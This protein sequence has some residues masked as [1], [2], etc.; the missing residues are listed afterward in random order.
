MLVRSP[1]RSSV[2]ITAVFNATRYTVTHLA[3]LTRTT[4]ILLSLTRRRRHTHTTLNMHSICRFIRRHSCRL[5][6]WDDSRLCSR[7]FGR[8]HRITRTT[9]LHYTIT[10]LEPLLLLLF[11][12]PYRH[13]YLL[14]YAHKILDLGHTSPPPGTHITNTSRDSGTCTTVVHIT[15]KSHS[16]GRL[17]FIILSVLHYTTL[18]GMWVRVISHSML[19]RPR[20]RCH[21]TLI[22]TRHCHRSTRWNSRH[23]SC[24][25]NDR[26]TLHHWA[27]PGGVGLSLVV[28]A[29]RPHHDQ[30]K[31]GLKVVHRHA[32]VVTSSPL[33][34]L[35][36]VC[37]LSRRI[38][39]RH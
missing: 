29:A 13:V 1:L 4:M 14:H 30:I 11:T 26:Y 8:H 36:W 22:V 35:R 5:S 10:C 28:V 6:R 23:I 27:I 25:F 9:G 2:S 24:L 20:P 38:I 16:H 17:C 33:Q 3:R 7:H 31:H 19:P 39:C 32:L 12:A 18:S 15:P 37:W 34:C 21:L